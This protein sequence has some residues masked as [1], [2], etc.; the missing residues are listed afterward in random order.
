[1]SAETP[2]FVS[3]FTRSVI[4]LFIRLRFGEN[5]LHR[6][7]ASHLHFLKG[8]KEILIKATRRLFS[9][10]TFTVKRAQPLQRGN[11]SPFDTI[12]FPSEEHREKSAF[13]FSGSAFSGVDPIMSNRKKTPKD[14][15]SSHPSEVLY[16][17][18]IRKKS[19]LLPLN[20]LNR[21]LFAYPLCGQLACT[22]VQFPFLLLHRTNLGG[23]ALGTSHVLA[24]A[25]FTPHRIKKSRQKKATPQSDL[26]CPGPLGN[27]FRFSDIPTFRANHLHEYSFV[28]FVCFFIRVL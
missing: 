21:P 22:F 3:F 4:R 20:S 11:D 10:R 18:G 1:M 2:L 25:R 26:R 6:N 19:D 14:S 12:R 8:A 5:R 17:S 24:I 27:H 13:L 16:T 23:V 9:L 7:K 15:A 28:I